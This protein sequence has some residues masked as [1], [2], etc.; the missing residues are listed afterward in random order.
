VRARDQLFLQLTDALMHSTIVL[1]EMS[2]NADKSG[3][4]ALVKA[5]AFSRL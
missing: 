4:S 3:R 2:A 1:P 5:F